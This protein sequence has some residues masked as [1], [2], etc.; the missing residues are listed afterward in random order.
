MKR[1][2]DI[3]DLLG[4][5][6]A[7][8][9][10]VLHSACAE[11]PRLAR[12]LAEHAA[13]LKGTHLTTLMPM[14][15]APYACES[16]AG[17][18]DIDTFFPGQGLRAALNH[19][20]ARPLRHALSEIP[21]LFSGGSMRADA[22]LLQTSVPDETGH[23][24]LGI[25]VDYMQAVLAQFPLVVAE[26][27]PRMPFVCGDTRLHVDQIDWFVDAEG[28]PQ[29]ITSTAADAVDVDIARNV[30][31]LLE[32]GATL[33]IGIGSL[34]D[35]VLSQLGH[36]QHLGVHSGVLTSAIQPLI[37][38]GVVDNSRKKHWPGVS[39]ATMACGTQSFYDFMHRNPAVE[40]HPCSRTHDR[41]MLASI[42]QLCAINGALQV[43]LLGDVNAEVVGA[44]R[45]SMPGGLPDFAAGAANS[46]GGKSIVALRSS[47]RNGEHSTIVARFNGGS[48]ISVPGRDVDFVV[49]EYGVASLRGRSARERSKALIQIAHPQHRET[50]EA[51][52]NEMQRIAA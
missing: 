23:V 4:R 14:G 46:L 30:A 20:R 13:S 1:L 22:L 27:N 3:G 44:R 6:G 12:A 7:G 31:G 17:H 39:V 5:L 25:S 38:S 51:A 36:L 50:L 33:Q 26:I 28:S 2:H 47:H 45:V 48:P 37:E 9:R 18:F 32:S 8:T 29:Q 24:S 11:P 21:G 35:R 52:V 42:D 16:V 49:T 10:I 41:K 15:S 19:G 43:D 34:P 40:L